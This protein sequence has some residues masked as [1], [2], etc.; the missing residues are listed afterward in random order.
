MQRVLPLVLLAASVL[1]LGACQAGAPAAAE[2]TASSSAAAS[3][4]PAAAPSAP[5][6]GPTGVSVAPLAPP[7]H[8]RWGGQGVLT[9]SA[10]FVAEDR[11]YFQEE[12][13][14]FEYVNFSNASEVVPAAANNQLEGAAVAP[15][16]ATLNALGR[17]AGLKLV[18]DRGVF[19]PGYGWVARV[20]R[21]DLVEIGRYRGPADLRGLNV[22]V[23]P[24]VGATSNAI[25]VD[26]MMEQ[27]GL[28]PDDVTF[29]PLG[30]PDMT[31]A[32]ANRSIDAA[33]HSEPLMALAIRQGIAVKVLGSDEIYP[34]Q[35]LGAVAYGEEFVRSQP[36]A[37]RRFVVAYLR[38][39]RDFVD[40]F[41]KNRGR[42]AVVAS[43][44]K[45]TSV[46]DPT[47]YD[48]MVPTGFNP[49]GYLNVDSMNADQEWFIREGKLAQ[50]LDLA[51]FVDHQ[52]V[53]YA[54]GRLGRYQQ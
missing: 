46:K 38:G 26:R 21:P 40:A 16:L 20:V 48:L 9:D 28:G 25:A 50:R 45:H 7:A 24:P 3:A 54:I 49:D 23:T 13:L 1:A 51:Q 14:D 35:Q 53:D 10:A 44:I 12:G 2:P 39:V 27:A 29:T 33:F 6:A 34:D 11:G 47:T 22:A 36:E 37:A 41:G 30:F 15:N 18:A 43:L 17:G 42:D 5:T 32:L 19:R 4:P 31:P 52:Y 8:V